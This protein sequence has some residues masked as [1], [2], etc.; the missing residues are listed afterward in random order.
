MR[1]RLPVAALTAALLIEGSPVAAAP[2][3]SACLAQETV[4]VTATETISTLNQG[5][6]IPN[7]PNVL[8]AAGID[9][10]ESFGA[11]VQPLKGPATPLDEAA[12]RRATLL[13]EIALEAREYPT[14]RPR[15]GDGQSPLR[16][17][18]IGLRTSVVDTR[19][20]DLVASVQW[21]AASEAAP[22]ADEA[23]AEY[24]KAHFPQVL[25]ETMRRV[26]NDRR[27]PEAR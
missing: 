7:R 21:P 10:L 8:A 6:R 17:I 23:V 20:R 27:R 16:T 19:N 24:V 5:D 2:S 12:A 13:V 9:W 26:C 4:A 14:A 15:S 22:S 3:L 25:A 1:H 18:K 11:G